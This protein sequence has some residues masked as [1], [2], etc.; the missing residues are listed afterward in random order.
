MKSLEQGRATF[1]YPLQVVKEAIGIGSFQRARAAH[2][3]LSKQVVY[4]LGQILLPLAYVME[5]DRTSL[6]A[7]MIMYFADNTAN[8]TSAIAGVVSGYYWEAAVAKLGYNFIAQVAPDVA[9]LAKS[10]VL[11]KT[12]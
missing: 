7:G 9:N 12:A 3:K 6:D 2:E 4:G 8:V 1:S 11:R 5:S 10:K